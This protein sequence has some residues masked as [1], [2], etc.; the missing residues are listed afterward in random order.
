MTNRIAGDIEASIVIEIQF[1]AKRSLQQT[2][3]TGKKIDTAS[4]MI[5]PW[6]MGFILVMPN[7]F[8]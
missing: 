3:F 7:L 2:P 6:E 4:S 8:S 5:G 1:A